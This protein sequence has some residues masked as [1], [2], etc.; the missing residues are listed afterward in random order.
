MKPLGQSSERITP[1]CTD[2]LRVVE[3]R[4]LGCLEHFRRGDMLYGRDTPVT[5]LF[6]IKSGKVK[7]FNLSLDGKAHTN[8]VWGP[9]G[10]LGITA[11]V[12]GEPHQTMAS[13][14][15]ETQV[16]VVPREDF[17]RLLMT[18]GTFAMS[19][20]QNLARVIKLLVREINLLCFSD[21]QDRLKE[22]LVKLAYEYGKADEECVQIDLKMTHE[23]MAEMVAANR[24]TIT[25]TLSDL[26]ERG[27]VWRE[28]QRYAILLPEHIEILDGLTQ[29]VVECNVTSAVAW[30]KRALEENVDLEKALDA[31][32]RGLEMSDVGGQDQRVRSGE[33]QA[34]RA[35]ERAASIIRQKTAS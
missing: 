23:E 10:L 33:T 13:A 22:S 16:W 26:R 18:D 29:A 24:T 30:A 27:Y 11:L 17:E 8:G 34:A 25:A 19:V 3:R 14:M 32:K 7:T 21:V 9:G 5:A 6:V 4:Q 12:L 20:M 31:L 15:E 1:L 35:F 28:G 2:I